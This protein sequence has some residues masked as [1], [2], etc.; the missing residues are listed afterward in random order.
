[1]LQPRWQNIVIVVLGI[2]T[3]SYFMHEFYGRD[4][5]IFHFSKGCRRVGPLTLA[6]FI[7][8]VLAAIW[9]AFLYRLGR[10]QKTWLKTVGIVRAVH[11]STTV[12]D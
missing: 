7:L 5:N 2:F 4:M 1:M 6:F 12:C 10:K 9:A 8:G 11:T 3:F